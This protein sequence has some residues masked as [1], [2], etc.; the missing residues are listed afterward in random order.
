MKRDRIFLV[1]LALAVLALRLLLAPPR[2]WLTLT[3]PVDLSDPA[4]AGAQVV[5]KYDCRSC[6]R[7]DGRGSLKAPDLAGVTERL[8]NVSLWLW[9]GNPK[10]VK[11][12]TAMPN[13]HLS[14][15]E[16]EAILAYLRALEARPV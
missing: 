5:E 3:K 14:D 16:I 10:A 2:W 13:F 11:G 9:L 15:A 12:N 4:T 7:I 6:H 1:A 8:D